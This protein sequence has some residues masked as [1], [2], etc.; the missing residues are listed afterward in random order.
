MF[1]IIRNKE[2]ADRKALR[3]EFE[4]TTQT[5][6]SAD[7]VTQVAV[8]HCINLA[9]TA[10]MARFSSIERFKSMAINEKLDYIKSLSR[11]EGGLGQRAEGGLGQ[12]AE[13]GLGQ[14]DAEAALG[15]GLFKMWIGAITAN[16]DQ[17]VA[18]FSKELA[19][20]SRKGDLGGSGAL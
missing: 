1:G 9:N 14:R 17:L 4:T 15:F 8:G 19:F 18:Q 3:L 20:F 2:R 11:A 12:R 16:D 5:L 13:G 6:H 7:E 10:F